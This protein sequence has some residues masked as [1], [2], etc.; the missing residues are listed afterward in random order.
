[1]DCAIRNS[2]SQASDSKLSRTISSGHEQGSLTYTLMVKPT[3]PR[4]SVAS[5][6]PLHSRPRKGGPRPPRWLFPLQIP[7]WV[8]T[9]NKDDLSKFFRPLS[10]CSL[11]CFSPVA[12]LRPIIVS[13]RYLCVYLPLVD[14]SADL[15]S[16]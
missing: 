14:S 15:Q 16:K 3:P 4:G 5:R 2:M 10:S 6:L 13:N 7:C 12:Q 9:F 8:N 1:M 11:L